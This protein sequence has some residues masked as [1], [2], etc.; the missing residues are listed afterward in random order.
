MIA[1]NEKEGNVERPIGE[2]IR[3]SYLAVRSNEFSMAPEHKWGLDNG[4]LLSGRGIPSEVPLSG[5]SCGTRVR[6]LESSVDDLHNARRSLLLE[7]NFFTHRLEGGFPFFC[8][9]RPAD[10]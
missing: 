2:A 4:A 8:L 3:A 6:T 1:Q 7:V 5:D 9:L 10:V